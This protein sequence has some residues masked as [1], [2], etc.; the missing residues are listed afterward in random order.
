M[1]SSDSPGPAG[2]R[3][4]ERF[5]RVRDAHQTEMAEDYVK[6]LA[7]L[8]DSK[9]EARLV[10]LAECL[11]V[12]KPTVSGAIRRLQREGLVSSE[13][14]RSI[15]LTEEGRGLAAASRERHRNVRELLVSQG[16]DGETADADA[17]GIEHHV[18]EATLA[19]F[20]RHLAQGRS[21]SRS[22][23]SPGPPRRR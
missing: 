20:R 2:A 5:K 23:S 1:P 3:Q 16:V 4:A 10:D 11:G 13:P 14:Y 15:F 7:Q 6:L 22:R 9:G 8:L 18:S 17:E 19:A 21:K 12:S